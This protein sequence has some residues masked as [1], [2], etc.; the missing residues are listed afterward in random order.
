MPTEYLNPKTLCPTFGWTHVAVSSG[1][2][3]IYISGQVA[4]DEQGKVVGVG[5]MKA[6]TEQAFRNVQLALEAAGATFADVVKTSLFVVGLKP[7]HVPLIREV[8]ARY[9]SKETPPTST[10]VGVSALV[11]PEWLIEIEAIAVLP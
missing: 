8:R 10:L 7:E 4:V 9:V 1:Q 3:T 2:R 11:G 5:D 6:Q